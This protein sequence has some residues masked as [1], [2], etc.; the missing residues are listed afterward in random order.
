MKRIMIY[1]L[2]P[3]LLVFHTA[4][5]FGQDS[6]DFCEKDACFNSYLIFSGNANKALAE[7]VAEYL[8]VSLGKASVKKF[9]DGEISIKINE[10]VRNKEVFIIQPTC[11]NA[12][13]SVND[14]MMELYLLIRTMKRS[15]A[16]SVTAIIPYY[17]YAR[18]DRK[19]APRVPISASDVAILL[20]GAG[21]DRIV[22]IDLHCGQI[23]GFFHDVPVD[24]LYASI[25]YVPY[26]VEKG[27]VNA[28][29][30]SPD[31]GGVD[32]AKKF[33]EY[34]SGQGVDANI[35]IISKQRAEAGVVDTMNLIGSVKDADAIIVDDLCDT[36]GTLVKAA[37]LLKEQGARN[38]YAAVTH[39]VFSKDALV[40]IGN[41]VIDEMVVTN[42][43]QLQGE[44]PANIKVLS[45]ASLLAETI[46]RIHYGESVSELFP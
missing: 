35:A 42:T 23:Q 26:F 25:V 10:N 13:Q 18:Q 34:L 4:D 3:F 15:S 45:V 29:V 33:Q 46:Q 11:S 17:G 41:S 22:S 1:A 37:E 30:V 43:I 39:P 14:S 20:E 12:S 8:G 9:N 38:V 7:E 2:M 36:G 24:N 44:R 40:K 31:A 32:R 5:L 21:A 19:S 16:A 6:G 27:L 28:V